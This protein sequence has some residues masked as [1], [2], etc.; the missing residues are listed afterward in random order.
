[1]GL[2]KKLNDVAN[3][4][5]GQSPESSSYNTEGIGEPFFQGKA[6]FGDMY[7][8]I[9]MYCSSPLKKAREKDILMSVRA[10]VGDVNICNI[11]C[12]IGRGLAAITPIESVLD[13]KY[14][15]YYLTLKKEQISNLGTGSTFKAIN[16]SIIEHVELPVPTIE[17]QHKIAILL[18]KARELIDKRKEQ[19]DA[20]D[21]LVKS[22]FYEIF[23][24]PVTNPKGWEIEPLRNLIT[25]AKYGSSQKADETKGRYPILR[26]NNITYQGDW[27]FSDLKY[28]DLE[29]KNEEKYL[30]EKGDL[31]FNRTN[32]KELVGKTAVYVEDEKMAFAGYLIRVR[33]NERANTQYISA[34]LNSPYGKQTLNNMCK[35][36]VGMANINAQELQDIMMAV[37]PIEMQNN[38]AM[39][40]TKINEQKK[41]LKKGLI[42]LENNFQALMQRA[43]KGELF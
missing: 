38:F 8:S 26:M 36:I 22:L 24:D 25:E 32:S 18:D 21:E 7:P 12:C 34:F 5:M 2:I 27:D 40:V 29:E 42:E 10:P 41:S 37:P 39:I 35:N 16:K 14:L 6:D 17:I 31:L 23:G 30:V 19:I 13:F 20:C 15:Y 43:F 11:S 1:M 9:R 33:T 3:I 4:N 28:I